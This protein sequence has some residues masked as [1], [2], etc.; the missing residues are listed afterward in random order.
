VAAA[1]NAGAPAFDY[2][3]G[4]GQG[5]HYAWGN[6]HLLTCAAHDSASVTV[7][8]GT[9][10]ASIQVGNDRLIIPGGALSQ[11]TTITATIPADTLADIHFEPH[12]LQFNKDV[13][14]VLS[15]NGCS[16]GSD[17]PDDIV[18]LDNAG[19]VLETLEGTFSGSGHTVTAKIHHFSSYAIAF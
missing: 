15:T 9:S 3:S 12:G 5:N 4:G 19:N 10:G 6:P 7:T 13:H 16:T 1:P 11:S 17:D 8:V 2:G 18:Y 14:L